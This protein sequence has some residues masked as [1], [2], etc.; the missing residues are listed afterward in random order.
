MLIVAERINSSRKPIS[1]A[2]KAKDA[3]FIRNEAKAQTEAGAQY[4]D[5]GPLIYRSALTVRTRR[6]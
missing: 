2:V 4:I 3:D 5:R 6:R 1:E